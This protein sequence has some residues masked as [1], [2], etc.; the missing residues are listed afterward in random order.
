MESPPTLPYR[1]LPNSTPA[2]GGVALGDPAAPYRG[3]R[4]GLIGG[5]VIFLCLAAVLGLMLLLTFVV[6]FTVSDFDLAVR[7]VVSILIFYGLG[8]LLLGWLGVDSIR[9][10]R[11]VQPI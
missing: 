3:Q 8:A 6:L 11:W 7:D 4:G 1:G 5:G 9:A 2:P 10:R